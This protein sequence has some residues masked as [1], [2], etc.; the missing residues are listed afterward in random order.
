M[1]KSFWSALWPIIFCTAFAAIAVACSDDD[2]DEYLYLDGTL[3]FNLDEYICPGHV[4][5]M[6]A[7]GVT[8][9]EGAEITYYWKVSCSEW[10]DDH[11]DTFDTD[12]NTV[13]TFSYT[14]GEELWT[15]TVSLTAKA[16]DYVS[17]TS[18]ITTMVVRGGI[19]GTGSLT[20][21]DGSALLNLAQVSSFI[22]ERDSQTYYYT[23]IGDYDWMI[24]N[25][26][27]GGT[28]TDTGLSYYNLAVTN[29]VFGT[30]YTFEEASQACPEGWE[31]PSAEIWDSC[32]PDNI[33]GLLVNAY[34]NGNLM[35]EFWPAVKISN[36]TLF[37]AIPAGEVNT[38]TQYFTGMKE[39]AVFWT[40]SESETDPDKAVVK[41][42]LPDQDELYEAYMDKSSFGANVR[43]VRRGKPTI[44]Y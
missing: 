2:D 30:Y 18:Q 41:Y 27:Y 33:G 37:S 8:H 39:R 14:F 26:M 34:F 44:E 35:W 13:G 38:A 15:Y 16:D 7:S 21:S 19:D 12:T 4:A 29:D 3:K 36:S 23:T 42:I 5:D 20:K 43:C 1:K 6:V 25:L 17:S 24:Q 40:S 11:D 31:L 10:D 28:G 32:L 22:D 9:P